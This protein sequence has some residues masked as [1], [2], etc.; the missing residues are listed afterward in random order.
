MWKKMLLTLT[1]LGSIAV[2][3]VTAEWRVAIQAFDGRAVSVNPL[4]VCLPVG[5]PGQLTTVK[6]NLPSVAEIFYAA[7]MG[8]S[9]GGNKFLAF[10]SALNGKYV[11]ARGAFN[12]VPPTGSIP[13]VLEAN[14]TPPGSSPV[15][16]I[17]VDGGFPLDSRIFEAVPVGGGWVVLRVRPESPTGSFAYS[18]AN[19]WIDNDPYVNV[20][21]VPGHYPVLRTDGPPP[22]DRFLKFRI[23]PLDPEALTC[24]PTCFWHCCKD[25]MTVTPLR[26]RPDPVTPVWK[27][28]I[29]RFY[30]NP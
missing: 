30:S 29:N 5:Y 6:T 24:N 26:P 10:R 2:A 9:Q 4:S 22:E 20:V 11:G 16:T 3:S 28:P 7:D 19:V 21:K 18:P 23:V 12:L 14:T 15:P 17:P 1:A 27:S 8:A 13:G 25:E